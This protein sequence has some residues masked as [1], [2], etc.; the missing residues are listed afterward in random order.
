MER[1]D[2]GLANEERWEEK[3]FRW[4]RIWAL[5][6]STAAREGVACSDRLATR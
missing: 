3:Y 6:A 4:L 1:G 2:D 5:P